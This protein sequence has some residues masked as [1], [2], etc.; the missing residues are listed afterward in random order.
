MSR[1]ASAAPTR[2]DQQKADTR[3]A[4]VRAGAQVFAAKGYG[5]ATM[6]EVAAAAGTS[7]ATVYLHSPT[8]ADRGRAAVD[9]LPAPAAEWGN[10]LPARVRTRAGTEAMVRAWVGFYRDNLDGFR[11][12]HE[13]AVVEPELE[14]PVQAT[15][16][17]IV[18]RMLGHPVLEATPR[19]ELA[20]AMT[21]LLFD[22]VL[23]G[24]LVQGWPVDE[25]AVVAEV[26]DAWHAWFLPRL[27]RELG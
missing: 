1:P 21:F 7:R 25:E 22:R 5:R 12:W 15:G 6:P 13:F 3:E 8:K 18:E 4:L 26:V 11:V 24:W 27:R 20:V 19:A 23:Y 14:P 17:A 9:D 10:E 2:R 16:S